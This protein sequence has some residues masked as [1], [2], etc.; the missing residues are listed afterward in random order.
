[1]DKDREQN[2]ERKEA[3]QFSVEGQRVTVVGG[4]R[5]G[6]AAAVL[7]VDRGAQVTLT[8]LRPSLERQADEQRL[9]AAGVALELGEHRAETFTAADLIVVSPGVPLQQPQLAAAR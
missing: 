5:S 2:T 9:K 4:A 8:D 1:M 6:I 3:A 7:L